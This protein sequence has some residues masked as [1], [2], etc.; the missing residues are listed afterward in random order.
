MLTA[1]VPGELRV[2]KDGHETVMAVSGGFMEVLPYQVTVLADAAERAE[3]IDVARAEA[4]R[5]R[6]A[7]ELA[8]RRLSAVDAAR[9]EAELRRALARLR[10]VERRRR[11]A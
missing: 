1:L 10:V 9:V 8:E 4:A 11:Q 5:A 7:A 2:K 3:E 6:A